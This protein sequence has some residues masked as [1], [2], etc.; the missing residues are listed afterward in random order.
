MRTSSLRVASSGSKALRLQSVVARQSELASSRR[1]TTSAQRPATALPITAT[2]PPPSAPVATSSQY[3]DRVGER[4]RKAELLKQG[5]ELRAE[6]QAQSGSG[7]R[8]SPLKKRFWKDVHVKEVPE[9]YQVHLD[10]RPVR[11]PAKIILT[12]P[13][14][15]PH[16]AHAI[17][18]EWDMLE[19]AQQALKNHNIPMTSIVARAQDI[20]EAEARGS[21]AIREEIITVMMRYLDT[22]TLLCWAPEHST[23]DATQLETHPD[24]KETLRQIQIKTATPIISYL[25]TTVWPGVELKPVLEEG[26]IMP[27]Q[28]SEMTRSVIRGWMAGL[29]AYELAALER[30]VLA[31]KSV[32]VGA[33][34]VVEWSEEFRDVQRSSEKRFGIE[35]AAEAATVEV[36]W[37]TAMWGEVEDTH[38]V[39]NEDIRRQL[40]S[41]ILLVSGVR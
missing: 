40:G 28:Q 33:R 37:Q 35:E 3:G 9:G 30:A 23:H 39:E 32:L 5:K 26:S 11:T 20:K 16:L 17:A 22:D 34:L 1:L 7:R 8:T 15:K 19:S 18:I 10:S 2:G 27:V 36:R 25:T 24:R 12:V 31:G 14:S 4:R 21:T 6:Q 38:D 29:P 13:R 41:A